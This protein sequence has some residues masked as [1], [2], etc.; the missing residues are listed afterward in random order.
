MNFLSKHY[1]KILLALFLLVFV[2]SLVYLIV[3]FSKSTD[4]SEDDLRVRPEGRNY[5]Q[6]FDTDGKEKIK[7]G[8]KPKY[9]AIA[10]LEDES[11]WRKSSK[12][13]KKD[14]IR[15]SEFGENTTPQQL[16]K[17]EGFISKK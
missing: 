4:I 11:A 14:E 5:E 16:T 10:E 15:L 8:E 6:I 17:E 9:A 7:E 3:V 13:D 1:E 12:R 2:F